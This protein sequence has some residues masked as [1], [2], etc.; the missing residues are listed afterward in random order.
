[1]IGQF[2]PSE[3]DAIT[4]V[5][6]GWRRRCQEILQLLSV[7]PG[8]RRLA[9]ADRA[10]VQTLYRALKNDTGRA[11]KSGSLS[12]RRELQT[13]AEQRFYEPAVRHAFLALHPSAIT[14]P[15]TSNWFSAVY[16]ADMEFAYYLH[17][18]ERP[19]SSE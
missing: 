2:D 14:H 3:I 4:A 5:L 6:E 7:D 19:T 13:Y 16:D 17:Q 8:E 1:M 10:R 18:M 12:G 9:R 11:A 15:L